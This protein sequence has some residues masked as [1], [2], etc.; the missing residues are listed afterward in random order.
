MD[1][2]RTIRGLQ[3]TVRRIAASTTS[4]S[5]TIYQR[6]SAVTL[7]LYRRVGPDNDPILQPDREEHSLKL[8]DPGL[9]MDGIVFDWTVLNPYRGRSLA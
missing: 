1:I 8:S 3:Q 5:V 2:V 6:H 9:R 7:L 4:T